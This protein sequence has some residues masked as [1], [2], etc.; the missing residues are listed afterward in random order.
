MITEDVAISDDF[1][2][3]KVRGM[4][5]KLLEAERL[6]ALTDCRSLNE[7]FR[8][9]YP[10]ESFEGHAP[11]QREIVAE[12]VRSLWR[13]RQYLS[14]KVQMLF[15]HMVRQF[16]LENLK[17]ALR[18]CQAGMTV[19]ATEPLMI[20]LP[21][22]LA[23][24]IELLLETPDPRRFIE[25]V[26][27]SE[28]R[29]VLSEHIKPA[30]RIDLFRCETALEKAYWSELVALAADVGERS[31]RLVT[32]DAAVHGVLMILRAKFDYQLDAEQ[33]ADDAFMDKEYLNRKT[34]D[35]LL[36]APDFEAAVAAVPARLLPPAMARDVL[37]V[38]ALED[39]LLLHQYRTAV[40]CFV[41]SVL[42]ISAVIAFYYIKRA[43]LSNLIRVSEGVRHSLPRDE[44]ESN[45]L[46]KAR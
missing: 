11:F 35:N 12:H 8:R 17:V 9:I 14:G 5:S 44:I 28:W 16:Q 29:G 15:T 2:T 4:R 21:K 34:V 23:L 1:I 45:L 3:A 27:D 42:D 37:S 22:E 46:M 26:Q 38:T 41:E 10:S 24:P 32:F 30:E 13:V 19:A 39:A 33:L 40:R 18:A 7:L 6:T 25:A 43:E 31:R 36:A 20:P